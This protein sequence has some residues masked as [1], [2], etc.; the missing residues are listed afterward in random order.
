M[1][2][3]ALN[4]KRTQYYIIVLLYYLYTI[5]V[6]VIILVQFFILFHKNHKKHSKN[7]CFY[8][9]FPQKGTLNDAGDGGGAEGNKSHNF[10]K[11]RTNYKKNN[12]HVFSSIFF[13]PGREL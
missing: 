2:F 1:H 11:H 7:N 9:L 13:S 10:S 4:K 3:G 12:K 6:H 8:N 5:C